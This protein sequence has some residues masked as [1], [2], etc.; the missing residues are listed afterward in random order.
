MHL[1]SVMINTTPI[2]NDILKEKKKAFF[3]KNKKSLPPDD[4]RLFLFLFIKN[5][6]SNLDF[7][8]N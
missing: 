5:L 6:T 2:F 4:E 3:I 8:P 1:N 7:V